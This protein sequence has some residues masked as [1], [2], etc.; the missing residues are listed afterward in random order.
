MNRPTFIRS[1]L[2]T[3]ILL[4]GWIAAAGAYENYSTTG[5]T[6]NCASCHGDFLSSPYVSLADGANW[7]DDL[8]DVHR[9]TMLSGDCNACHSSGGRSPV[10]LRSSVGGTGLDPIS[11]LGCHGRPETGGTVTGAGLRQHHW[12]SGVTS[13]LGCHSDSNPAAFTPVGENVPPPY[14]AI[15]DA[16]HPTKPS[17]PC[18]PN[19]EED[20]AGTAIG[21]DN[22]GDGFYDQNDSDCQV[23]TPVPDINLGP[24][25]LNFGAIPAGG[26][27]TLQTAIQNL[28]TLDLEV[29]LIDLCAGTSPEFSWM[30]DA[31]FTVAPGSSQ[32][33]EVTYAP[34]DEGMDAGCLAISSNDPD[35]SVRQLGLNL[36]S[37]SILRFLPVIIRAGQAGAQ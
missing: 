3:P 30:P 16:A 34:M 20:F 8:H 33:L 28:G 27:A 7:G 1:A 35:E 15:P 25:R 22:D 4:A 2:L 5:T 37:S 11:C 10:S 19:G 24:G 23:S 6:G 21:L 36:T 32:I 14:Y 9:T 13:C 12:N 17:D 29:T 26:S 18:N 31:P